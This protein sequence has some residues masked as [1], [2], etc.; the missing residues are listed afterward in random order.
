MHSEVITFTKRALS[1]SACQP[2]LVVTHILHSGEEDGMSH[3]D[4]RHANRILARDRGVL[5]LPGT[6]GTIFRGQQDS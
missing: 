5:S 2:M 6:C 4:L 3:G 1:L